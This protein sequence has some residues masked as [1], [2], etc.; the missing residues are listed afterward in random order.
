MSASSEIL[1]QQ[2][3]RLEALRQVLQ[4]ESEA[5]LG[6]DWARVRAIAAQKVQLFREISTL[7]TQRRSLRGS[8]EEMR[9]RHWLLQ[10]IAQINRRNGASIQALGQFQQE[11]WRILFGAENQLYD[12]DGQIG[13]GKSGHRLGSA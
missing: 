5:L 7:E 1:S 10:E 9:Q 13:K 12:D 2:L 4:A 11:A 6:S 8:A 3:T